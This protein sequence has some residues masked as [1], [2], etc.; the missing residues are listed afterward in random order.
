MKKIVAIIGSNKADSITNMI[1]VRILKKI[2][3]ID[4]NFTFSVIHLAHYKIEYCM[5]CGNCCE[6][7]VCPIS[8]KDDV[9]VICEDLQQADI[10][11]FASPVYL[12]NV[13]GIMKSF[14]DRIHN[15]CHILNFAGKLGFTLTTTFASGQEKVSF[16]LD[17]IQRNIGIK[18]LANFTYVEENDDLETMIQNSVKS[19][20]RCIELNFGL[21]DRYLEGL[22]EKLK[23]E[24]E[25]I[26]KTQNFEKI[27]W[28]QK[29]IRDCESFQEYAVKNNKRGAKNV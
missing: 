19:F 3:E 26:S 5:G 1:V 21:T 14:F 17:F 20:F 8:E 15:S 24:I 23:N 25:G 7:G 4:K 9:K 22:F 28:N 11:F 27:Y 6:Q 18:N 10:V 13:S 16:Y 29:W 2:V 12:H